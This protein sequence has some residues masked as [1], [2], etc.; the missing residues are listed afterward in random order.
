VQL[1]KP[2]WDMIG[3]PF[4]SPQT[5]RTVFLGRSLFTRARF[6]R[7]RVVEEFKAMVTRL[8]KDS[9]K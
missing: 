5:I 6:Y 8:L 2:A 9:G 4:G 7:S 1:F 3:E